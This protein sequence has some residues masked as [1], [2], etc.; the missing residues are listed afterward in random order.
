MGTGQPSLRLTRWNFKEFP[1]VHE[2][3][4]G[5]VVQI[6]R[7]V[8][9]DQSGFYDC[10]FNGWR[11]AIGRILDGSLRGKSFI[12]DSTDLTEGQESCVLAMP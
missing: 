12:I 1:A 9:F 7:Y 6:D 2:V 4:A 10:G 11:F 3:P 8:R 5:T